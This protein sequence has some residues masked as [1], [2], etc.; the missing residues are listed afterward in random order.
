MSKRRHATLLAA[1]AA[2]LAIA[3]PAAQADSI[4][5]VKGGNVW[6]STSDGSRQFQVTRDGGYSDASQADNG[7]IIA[8]HGL[9][10]RKLDRFGNVLADFA[11][12][13]SDDRPPAVRAFWGPFDPAI[14]PDGTKVAYTYYYVSYSQDPGCMPPLCVTHETDVGIG[15]TH[16]DRM[17]SWDEPGLGRQSGWIHPAWFDNSEVL[18]SDPARILNEDVI[19]DRVGDGNQ[20]ITRWFTDNGTSDVGAGDVTRQRTK[21]AFVTGQASDTLRVYA[22][23]GAAPALP[24]ACY[25]ISKPVGGSFASPTF[26]PDGRH[27][28][29]AVGNGV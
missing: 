6:L 5:Y 3:A 20:T 9:R 25:E 21:L 17:T 7:T 22:M 14:S 15:Y 4:S 29:Y 28:A 10:L 1:A 23:H 27:L 16:S 26:S 19:T 12:P 8:L 11:T 24:D 2:A 18:L 13:V